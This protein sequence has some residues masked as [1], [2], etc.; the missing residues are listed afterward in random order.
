MYKWKS[1]FDTS[2]LNSIYLKIKDEKYLSPNIQDVFK[3]FYLCPYND[4]KVV[5]IGQDPYPQKD[6]A[7]GI[8]FGN[9]SNTPEE[10]LSPSLQVIKEAAVN[11]EINHNA[12]YFDNSLEDWC[13]QGVLLLNSALTC[14]L[15]QPNSHLLL[16]R[17]FISKFLNNL[18]ICHPGL[19]YVLFGSTAKT[20]KP[21]IHNGHIIE[22]EHP[23]WF[24][25][26][27]KKMPSKLFTD[28][29]KLLKTYFDTTIEW[30]KE[31]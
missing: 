4:V 3:A 22:M 8:A 6:V 24:V 9:F 5:M 30:Y 23:A 2:T 18:S 13:K 17:P 19:I 10:D 16:W 28:I 14:R 21:Y 27:G 7:T 25:R 29:N 20:F 31:I 11:Y 26:T 15:R 12:Y 1:L